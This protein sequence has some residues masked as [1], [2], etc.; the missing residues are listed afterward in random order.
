MKSRKL[1]YLIEGTIKSENGIPISTEARQEDVESLCAFIL[2]HIHEDNISLIMTLTDPKEMWE[3][4]GSSH[5][6]NSFGSCYFHLRT[7]MSLLIPDVDGINNNLSHVESIG[8][9]LTKL[10]PEGKISIEEIKIAALTSSL[11]QDLTSTTAHFEQRK[12]V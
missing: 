2:E 4:L 3:A 11:P 12:D 7:F 5:L 8:A 1:Y 6:C 9:P 10:C